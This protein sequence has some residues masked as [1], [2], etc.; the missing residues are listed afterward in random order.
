MYSNPNNYKCRKTGRI[1]SSFSYQKL[2][3]SAKSQYDATSEPA[4]HMISDVSGSCV[5]LDLEISISDSLSSVSFDSS[6]AFDTS[7]SSPDFGGG[8]FGGGGSGGDF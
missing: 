6:S 7:S 2:S 3:V 4:T 1:I 8:D 5:I